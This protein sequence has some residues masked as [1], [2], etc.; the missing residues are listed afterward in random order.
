[1]L[2]ITVF[3]ITNVLITLGERQVQKEWAVQRY[4]ELQTIG[5]LLADKI[6]F[7]QFRTQMFSRAEPLKHFLNTP[8][9]QE[10]QHLLQSWQSLKSNIPELMDIALYDANGKFRLASSGNFSNTPLS[11]ALLD[12]TQSMGGDD[13]YTSNVEFAPVDD[14]LEP[15]VMQMAWLE[16]ADQSVRGYLV[17][18]NSLSQMLQSIKPAFSSNDSPMLLLDNQGQLYAGA[19][20]LDPL[21]GIPDTLGSSLRQSYPLLWRDLANNNF[22]EFH[23]ALASFVYLKISLASAS[24]HDADY[25][26][27]SYIRNE[28]ISE[29][30]A[31]WRNILLV[32]SVIV[33]LLAA[34]TILLIHLFRLEQRARL[35]SIRLADGLFRADYGCLLI[36]DS[37]RIVCANDTAATI[38][39]QRQQDIENR[40]LQ[41]L[42]EQEQQ[43]YDDVRHQLQQNNVWQG[44]VQLQALDNMVLHFNIRIIGQGSDGYA[45]ISFE[46]ISELKQ[47][48]QDA[49]LNQ[50]LSDSAVATALLTPKGNLVR[51]N[52]AF[53]QMLQLD[54]NLEHTLTELLQNDLDKQW[55]RIMQS[56]ATHG[57]WQGQIL[58]QDKRP[59][60]LQA[61]LK[62]YQDSDGELSYLICTLERASNIRELPGPKI[63]HRIKVMPE[64]DDLDNFFNAMS[65][66]EQQHSCLMVLDISPEALLSHMSEIESLETRQQQVETQV[67]ADLPR[68]Y[69]IANLQLGKIAVLLPNTDATASHHFAAQVLE[70]LGQHGLANGVCIGI[71]AYVAGQSL[72]QFLKNA[73]V[74]LKR[75]KQSGERNICQAFTRQA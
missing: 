67:L 8:G 75:A 15:Y 17:T 29:R 70:N 43:W 5:T 21:P 57:L 63:P 25:L 58:C 65:P 61:T 60:C 39:K 53:D 12:S 38:L 35:G 59:G 52:E 64:P 49:F 40:S 9:H 37:G 45:L 55:P 33:T 26:L 19:S 2:V 74:A 10:E 23:G 18:Y 36:N 32:T 42:L 69:Q 4:S 71:A 66:Q 73:E 48:R 14:R 44:E 50:L 30:F 22:G 31:Q 3:L 13:I 62:S 54:G 16:N 11:K 56:V 72:Q 20:N 24:Q 51:V 27:L 34:L 68:G 41:K 46:D 1:M 7:Q 28:D 6:S 47:V